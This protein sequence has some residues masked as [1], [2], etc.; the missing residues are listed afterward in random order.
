MWVVFNA[1]LTTVQRGAAV[2]QKIQRIAYCRDGLKFFNLTDIYNVVVK[3][4]RLFPRI[5]EMFSGG[6]MPVIYV[7]AVETIFN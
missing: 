3:K 6:G 4:D 2:M 1:R 7:L 5:Y